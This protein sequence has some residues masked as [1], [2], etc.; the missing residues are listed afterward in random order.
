VQPPSGLVSWWKAENNA[1]DSQ[2]SNHGTLKNGAM[3]AGG[4]V[5]QAFSLDGVN[6]FVEVPDSA[7]LDI[8]DV[9]TID[10]WIKTP[11]TGG[12]FAGIVGK[13]PGAG[14]RAGYLLNVDDNG[15][16]RCD[17]IKDV[18]SQGADVSTTSVA[19]DNWHPVAC[20]YDGT[21]VRAYVDGNLEGEVSYTDEIGSND[22][23]LRIGFDPATF[24][25]PRF[26][27]GL[28]DEVE[29]FNRALC[30]A[31][32]KAI[33]N[34]G[35]A[36]KCEGGEVVQCIDHFLCY[37]AKLTGGDICSSDAPSNAG[38]S[39]DTEEDCGGTEDE[40]SFCVPNKFP[41]GV[42]VS[43]SDQFEE[44]TFDVKRRSSQL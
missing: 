9:I 4:K 31:E 42:Q 27:N 10:A 1:N 19:D 11:G 40:T 13:M 6:D 2:D 44:G 18:L 33:F 21:K 12:K 34:A 35:S 32:I 23:P 7:N 22:E 39:C 24:L 43:L 41:K 30:D 14:S 17:I 28:I 5:G 36:G 29:I 16:F 15:K 25:G 20:T 8:T 3:F 26:F 38:G 37:K